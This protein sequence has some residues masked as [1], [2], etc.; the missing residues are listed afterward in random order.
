MRVVG[1]DVVV[2]NLKQQVRTL[3]VVVVSA[4]V[5]VNDHSILS[6]SAGRGSLL[7]CSHV[8]RDLVVEWVVVRHGVRSRRFGAKWVVCRKK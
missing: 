7:E 1:S 4:R 3:F 6:G 8:A 2:I 5:G